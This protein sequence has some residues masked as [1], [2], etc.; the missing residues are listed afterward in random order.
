MII[1]SLTC[2]TSV[3]NLLTQVATI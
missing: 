1:L 3:A 2:P